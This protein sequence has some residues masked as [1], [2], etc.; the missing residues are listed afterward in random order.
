[1]EGVNTQRSGKYPGLHRP[2]GCWEG[3]SAE[4]LN[5]QIKRRTQVVRIFPTEESLE[6]PFTGVLVEISEC[7]ESGS[8]YLKNEQN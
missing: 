5:S 8:I 4:N 1:M 3:D 6:C 7:W 2:L